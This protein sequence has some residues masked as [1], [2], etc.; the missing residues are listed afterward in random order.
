M[1]IQ[2]HRGKP[3]VSYTSGG[4]CTV[5]PNLVGIP[6]LL[7]N[8]PIPS[9]PPIPLPPPDPKPGTVGAGRNCQN[10]SHHGNSSACVICKGAE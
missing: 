6:G 8:R 1:P 2:D 7:G 3:P 10:C 4:R 9:G 5:T